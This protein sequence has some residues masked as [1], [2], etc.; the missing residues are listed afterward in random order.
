[1]RKV[2]QWVV[3]LRG[4]LSQTGI[5]PASAAAPAAEVTPAVQQQQQQSAAA[6]SAGVPASWSGTL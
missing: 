5:A 6:E 3:Q 1:M 4:T 2:V